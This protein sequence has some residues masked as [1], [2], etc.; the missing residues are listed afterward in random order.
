MLWNLCVLDLSFNAPANTGADC[1]CA[2]LHLTCAIASPV[3]LCKCSSCKLLVV[4]GWGQGS[5]R[6]SEIRLVDDQCNVQMLTHAFHC[7][8]YETATEAT[9]TDFTSV[10][11]GGTECWCHVRTHFITH[12]LNEVA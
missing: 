4:G 9:C 12:T 5:V 10:P 6:I 2:S 1:E 7:S 11:H 3:H 8:L